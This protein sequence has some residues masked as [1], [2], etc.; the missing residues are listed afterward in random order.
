MITK[1]HIAK[2]DTFYKDIDSVKAELDNAYVIAR[3]GAEERKQ[4][5][6][7]KID[8]KDTEVEAPEDK[9]WYEVANLGEDC[10]AGKT[11]KAIYPKV[12]ELSA[13]HNALVAEMTAYSLKEIG[14]DP[15]RITLMDILRIVD[16][17]IEGRK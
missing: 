8:G 6:M 2:M 16:G 5:V 13:K 1:E 3:E 4:K 11:L 9:L 17:V 7:R 12:F 10:E 14:I 15:M